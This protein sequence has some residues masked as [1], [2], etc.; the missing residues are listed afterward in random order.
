MTMSF[1]HRATG[2]ALYFGALLVAWWLLAAATSP[3]AFATANSWI[4][5]W[6]GLF[7]LFG[8]TWSLI[9]HALGGVR[10]L[11]WDLG[12]GLEKDTTTRYAWATIIGSVTLTL[13]FWVAILFARG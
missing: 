7:V 6:L 1:V 11:V 12:Y 2:A 5:S 10:H 8:F 4:G 13:L 9:H 3:Q